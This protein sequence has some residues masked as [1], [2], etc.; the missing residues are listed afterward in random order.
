MA[1]HPTPEDLSLGERVCVC[2][3]NSSASVEI[4]R[5]NSFYNVGPRDQMQI[6]KSLPVEPSCHPLTDQFLKML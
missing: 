3:H 6:I 2:A 1:A 4:R 5:T